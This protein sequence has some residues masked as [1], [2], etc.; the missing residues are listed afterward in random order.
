M[1]SLVLFCRKPNY[2]KIKEKEK[3]FR[4][5]KHKE[6]LERKHEHDVHS[7]QAN[8]EKVGRK[9]Q[10]DVQSLQAQN[11]SL[12]STLESI[13]L[14]VDKLELSDCTRELRA[15]VDKARVLVSQQLGCSTW[16]NVTDRVKH[17]TLTW[18]LVNNTAAVQIPV[19]LKH[20]GRKA[21]KHWRT[22]SDTEKELFVRQHFEMLALLRANKKLR[23]V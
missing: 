19:F 12:T 3:E 23:L 15:W 7:L 21:V 18:Q 22:N 10:Q 13:Q 9:L 1:F 11:S 5:L 8:T 14:R 20:L 6:K 17:N 4:L 16:E 2:S